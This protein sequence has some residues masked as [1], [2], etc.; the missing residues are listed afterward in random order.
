[1]GRWLAPLRR[2]D[3]QQPHVQ[4]PIGYQDDEPVA[5]DNVDDA[6]LQLRSGGGR[7]YSQRQDERGDAG[8]PS[9]KSCSSLPKARERP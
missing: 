2:V 4:P 5:I 3:I 1:M 6:A 8:A 9:H 7:R